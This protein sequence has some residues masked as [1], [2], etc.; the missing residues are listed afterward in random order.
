MELEEDADDVF[1]VD[2]I[3]LAPKGKARKRLKTSE[4]WKK[5][6]AKR[7]RYKSKNLPKMPTCNHKGG[8]FK[9]KELGMQDV[10]QMHERFYANPD[11][12]VQ[13]EFILKFVTVETPHRRRNIRNLQEKKVTTRYFLNKQRNGVVTRVQ[14]GTDLDVHEWKKAVCGTPKHGETPAVPDTAK[15][16]ANWHF[17]FMPSKKII[18]SKSKNP[19]NSTILVQGE[20]GY[21]MDVGAAKSICRKGK[22]WCQ[23]SPEKINKRVLLKDDKLNDLKSLLAKHYGHDWNLHPNLTFYKELLSEQEALL[24]AHEDSE[25]EADDADEIREDD[26]NVLRV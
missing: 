14:L 23:T 12:Q 5:V 13:N 2:T 16:P 7:E 4:N 18:L 10:R 11:R 26:E 15:T 19:S 24:Q 21:N 22:S 20:V 8:P 6:R 17:Q 3:T 1:E 25:E 9:C